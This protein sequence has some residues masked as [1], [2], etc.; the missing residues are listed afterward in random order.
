MGSCSHS[1][2]EQKVKLFMVT[3]VSTFVIAVPPSISE[4]SGKTAMEGE[5][6]TL[7]C[8]AEGK[9]TP[10]ITWTRLS[11]N[12]VVTMPLINISRHD[13]K[14]YRCTEDNGFKI[15]ATRDVSIDVKCKCYIELT[16]ESLNSLFSSLR[17]KTI[18]HWQMKAK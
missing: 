11:D 10:S 6:L 8:I 16:F 13:E 2:T 4:I 12:S 5:N 7:K 1:R 18:F 17:N 14:N 15:P 9:P 3:L